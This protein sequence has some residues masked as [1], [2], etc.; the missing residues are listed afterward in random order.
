MFKN[1]RVLVEAIHKTKAEKLREK[2]IED[3]LM[4]RRSK[5]KATKER[6]AIR[7]EERLSSVR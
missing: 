1:K 6:K 3:Q 5:N 2:A 7:R 4:A